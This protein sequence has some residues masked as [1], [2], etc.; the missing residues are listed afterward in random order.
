MYLLILELCYSNIN[1]HIHW[2]QRA[3]VFKAKKN[4]TLIINIGVH[5]RIPNQNL[6]FINSLSS[7]S[8]AFTISSRILFLVLS[9][10]SIFYLSPMRKGRRQYFKTILHYELVLWR[11]A[12]F[13]IL[14]FSFHALSNI[15]IKSELFYLYLSGFQSLI[16][17]RHSK[18]IWL[19]HDYKI[20]LCSSFL[21]ANIPL[22]VLF[23]YFLL[24]NQWF[25]KTEY[26]YSIRFHLFAFLFIPMSVSESKIPQ[27]FL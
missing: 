13:R 26:A 14:I 20:I 10:Y 7:M 19:I 6:L 2:I 25:C 15:S 17:N 5:V 8:I 21:N 9:F 27:D 16:S 18:S 11:I 3:F 1:G 4:T 12:T 24:W 23:D 22:E